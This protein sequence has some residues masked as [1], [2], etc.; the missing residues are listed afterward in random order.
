MRSIEASSVMQ[1]LTE[2]G[3]PRMDIGAF[4]AT[5]RIANASEAA[6]PPISSVMND[7]NSDVNK[8]LLANEITPLDSA[9][10]MDAVSLPTSTKSKARVV[11]EV[12][13]SDRMLMMID[14]GRAP[15]WFIPRSTD[16]NMHRFDVPASAMRPTSDQRGNTVRFFSF[17]RIPELIG[18]SARRLIDW[19]NANVERVHTPPG[20]Q[21]IDR[22]PTGSNEKSLLFVHGAFSSTLGAFDC[23]FKNRK[24]AALSAR[25]GQ[26]YG[27]DH[28]TVSSSVLENAKTLLESLADGSH[29]DVVCHSRGALVVRAAIEHP[30]LVELRTRKRIGFGK[31][32]F[33]AGAN[34]GTEL[35]E[36][37]NY[38]LLLNVFSLL[39]QATGGGI[40]LEIVFGVL[41]GLVHVA[42]E[43]PGL[44]DLTPASPVIVALN[45]PGPVDAER[46]GAV[47]A[48]SKPTGLL[49]R[50]VDLGIDALFKNVRN[51]LVVPFDGAERSDEPP[52]VPVSK[53]LSFPEGTGTQDTVHHN[54]FF[55][56]G[57]SG[58]SA[59]ER[60]PRVDD[61]RPG[62]GRSHQLQ[63]IASSRSS[64][65]WRQSGSRRQSAPADRSK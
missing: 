7:P 53:T 64:K 65:G 21:P 11:L 51:D 52:Q 12:E 45:Q 29:H 9:M 55:C 16:G 44:Q 57:K 4:G 26:V 36:F 62:G 3:M 27:F 18:A 49:L 39:A 14:D 32:V 31:V 35:A 25:Y 40:A 38:Q 56:P 61:Q 47:R 33:V 60:A 43:L 41:K 54:N 58:R 30:E 23:L 24:Y 15:V 42:A 8:A 6:D 10:R 28:A 34:Q 63:T 13:S 17:K 5:V 48:D 59:A 20:L 2:N 19:V 22:A 37:S 46:Y 50:A 1:P